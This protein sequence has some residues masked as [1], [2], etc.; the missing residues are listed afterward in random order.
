MG[1]SPYLLYNG[2]RCAAGPFW[3]DIGSSEPDQLMGIHRQQKKPQHK[4]TWTTVKKLVVELHNMTSTLHTIVE[5]L[6]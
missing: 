2:C 5:T 1:K 3:Y 4:A 6:R